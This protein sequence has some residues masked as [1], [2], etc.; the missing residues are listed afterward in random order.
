MADPSRPGQS[1]VWFDPFYVSHSCLSAYIH[2]ADLSRQGVTDIYA[3][4][5]YAGWIGSFKRDEFLYPPTFLVVMRPLLALSQDFT[6]LRALWFVLESVVTLAA[7]ATL[8]SWVGGRHGRSVALLIPVVWVATPTLLTLQT[9]NFQIIALALSVL[10]MIAFDRGRPASGG[11]LLGFAVAAKLFPGILVLYLMAQRRW[12]A[13]AWTALFGLFYLLAALALVGVAPFASFLRD[14]LPRLGS[15]AAWPW[16]ERPDFVVF[17]ALNHSVPGI[18]WK[19]RDLGATDLG[20][21][22]ARAVSW[23][24]SLALLGL[25]SV[26]AGR[27]RE[28]SR[29]AQ[30]QA[31]IALVSLAALRSAFV[32]DA[33]ALLGPLWLLALASSQVAT[34]ARNLAGIVI[35]WV[36][37]ASVLP[38][39]SAFPGDTPRLVISLLVQAVM[40]GLLLW[41]AL[42]SR[43]TTAVASPGAAGW[44]ASAPVSAALEP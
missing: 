35:A 23:L 22:A 11:A 10:G 16:L 6:R 5:H 44:S 14:V 29:V 8:A 39:D 7:L 24:Y 19:L 18:V 41:S 17:V 21:D 33:S 40:L 2:A 38:P 13:V 15:G 9:G 36:L 32:P 34:R 30:A 1:A 42:R 43:E 4:E 27:L 28:A 26:V 3:R 31:W 37:M 12:K 25:V 20:W